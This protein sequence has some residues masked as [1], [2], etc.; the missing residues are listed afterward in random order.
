VPFSTKTGILVALFTFGLSWSQARAEPCVGAGVIAKVEGDYRQVTV[1]R[2]SGRVFH[3]DVLD[4]VCEGDQI[5]AGAGARVTIAIDGGPPMTL[6]GQSTTIVPRSA[7]R[8][9]AGNF[10]SVVNDKLRPDITRMQRDMRLKGDGPPLAFAIATLPDGR[11]QVAAGSRGLLV[12]VRGGT[13][14]YR[15]ALTGPGGLSLAASSDTA[16]L[17]FDA[18]VFAA[19]RYRIEA[20]DA[21]GAKIAAEFEAAPEPA[22][23]AD[24]PAGFSDPE[25]QAATLAALLVRTD[26]HRALE[27]EQMVAASPANGLDRERIYDL[28]ESYSTN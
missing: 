19:G 6:S 20:A 15:A 22:A 21:Q 10:Y 13:G 3:P 7:A 24:A 17:T 8:S 2:R 18:A 26:K 9:L 12:R 11:Q 23:S 28:I 1:H 16:A 4:V 5:S 27:A 25:I 14:P